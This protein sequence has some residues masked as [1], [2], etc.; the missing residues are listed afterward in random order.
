LVSITHNC[1][2]QQK[3]VEARKISNIQ[4][5]YKEKFDTDFVPSAIRWVSQSEEPWNNPDG[6]VP[7]Q[8][9]HDAMYRTIDGIVDRWHPLIDPVSYFTIPPL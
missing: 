8:E 7:L 6:K 2:V 1:P 5:P 4:P 3:V 9:I